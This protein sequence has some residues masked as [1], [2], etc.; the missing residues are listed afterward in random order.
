MQM[1][2]NCPFSQ[3]SDVP[4]DLSP[5]DLLTLIDREAR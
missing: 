3:F 1:D 4:D 5:L 2:E